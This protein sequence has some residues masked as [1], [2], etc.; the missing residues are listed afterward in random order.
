[1]QKLS[2]GTDDDD[3][4]M[5]MDEVCLKKSLNISLGADFDPF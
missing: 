4:Y 2:I 3:D 1:M 5:M